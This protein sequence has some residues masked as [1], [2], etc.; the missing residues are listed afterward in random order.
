MNPVQIVRVLAV[1]TTQTL[2]LLSG[3]AKSFRLALPLGDLIRKAMFLMLL[4][5][6]QWCSGFKHIHVA[7]QLLSIRFLMWSCS[8]FYW[9]QNVD[10]HIL[11]MWIPRFSKYFWCWDTA[12]PIFVTWWENRIFSILK[13]WKSQGTKNQNFPRFQNWLMKELGLA[14]RHP[15][16][17]QNK[18][19]YLPERTW[20]AITLKL[21]GD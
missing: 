20:L 8:L 21:L 17:I 10:K 4:T 5:N 1:T 19:I 6:S 7:I 2:L 9:L 15:A 16:S 3:C 14:L 11:C 12:A 13:K 18:I